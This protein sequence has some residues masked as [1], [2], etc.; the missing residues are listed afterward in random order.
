MVVS[1]SWRTEMFRQ[2]SWAADLHQE[3]IE[4]WLADK[5]KDIRAAAQGF[6][7]QARAGEPLS[8]PD[9]R[10]IQAYLQAMARIYPEFDHVEMLDITSQTRFSSDALSGQ[11]FTRDVFFQHAVLSAQG[12]IGQAT[13]QEGKEW[14]LFRISYPI[15]DRD[16]QVMAL[17][18]ATVSP[19][20]LLKQLLNTGEGLGKSGEVVLVND[21]VVLLN[22]LK[23]S[24]PD[25]THP[26]PMQLQISAKPAIFA[27]AGHEGLVEAED[28]RQVVVMAA[29]R[30]IRMNPEWGI[31]LVVKVDR[32][33]LFAPLQREIALTLSTGLAGFVLLVLMLRLMIHRQTRRLEMLGQAAARLTD[34]APVHHCGVRGQDEIG[35]LGQTFDH[36]ADR[37]QSALRDLTLEAT[38]HRQTAAELVLLNDE[39]RNF[40]YIVSHDLRSP[41]LSIQGFSEELQLDLQEL[42]NLVNTALEKSDAGEKAAITDLLDKRLPEDLTFIRA[43]T[44]KMDG[45]INA[46]LTLS[47]LGRAVLRFEPVDMR[48]L[49]E[50]NVAALAYEI[51]TAGVTVTVG[52]LPE[53]ITDPT[54]M[55][56]VVGNLLSNAVKYLDP[57][58]PG[59]IHI[60]GETDPATGYATLQ[61][62]DNG[63]GISPE[64]IDKIFI[65]FQRVG[66]QNT[67]GDGMGLAYVRSWVRRLG[68][69]IQCESTLGTG[70]C[71]RVTLPAAPV[72]T[73]NP[74]EGN[75]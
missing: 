1:A 48:R 68:G 51:Q 34:V 9:T 63:R 58:R 75:G 41:L 36:M 66:Q 4:N 39:L 22:P 64:D 2:L 40:I 15:R 61:I 50:D 5:Q 42:N 47:R 14:P 69:R 13:M 52:D 65:L 32:Q 25:G 20:S 23:H 49:V 56:Q 53:L 46:I 67:R 29:F 10:Q 38:K 33:D 26:Q 17:L 16:D 18:V 55:G 27:A 57:E 73:D 28:Y 7:L 59:R 11:S 62:T 44:H 3:M 45:L 60:D 35:L 37:I 24:L 72:S 21:Q 19:S 12:Y 43:A 8:V 70:S 54:A 71:F 31:G 6:R 30:H 74:S